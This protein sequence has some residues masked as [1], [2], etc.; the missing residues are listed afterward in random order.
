M[1]GDELGIPLHGHAPAAEVIAHDPFVVVLAQHQDKGKR[2]HALPDVTQRDARRPLSFRPHV[3]AIAAAAQ[4]ERPLSDPELRVDLERARMHR[5]RPRLLCRPRVP[6]Y[7]HRAHAAPSEL[8]GEHQSGRTGS[9]DQ[10]IRVHAI[11]LLKQYRLIRAHGGRRARP[12]MNLGLSGQGF[13]PISTAV[14]RISVESA[15]G[16]SA[17]TCVNPRSARAGPSSTM[18]ACFATTTIPG[19]P[20][21]SFFTGS[22]RR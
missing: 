8:I 3:G 5:H 12:S 18:T 4:L 11:L 2:A 22:W 19:A 20:R 14:S 21:R 10:H 17:A 1:D 6:V 15:R 9:H 16:D 13:L 7:D